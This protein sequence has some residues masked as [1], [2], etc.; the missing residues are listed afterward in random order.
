MNEHDLEG[1]RENV[2]LKGGLRPLSPMRRKLDRLWNRSPWRIIPPI[3]ISY[4]LVGSLLW[5]IETPDAWLRAIS[6]VLTVSVFLFVTP[7]VRN[8][9]FKR[10]IKKL[11]AEERRE[12]NI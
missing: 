9:W 5:F 2:G 1:H 8:K 11:E 12:R 4:V 3:A 6:P 7:Y 10:M